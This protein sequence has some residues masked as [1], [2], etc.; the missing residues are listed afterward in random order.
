MKRKDIP[1]DKAARAHA[2]RPSGL[3]VSFIERN[4]LWSRMGLALSLVLAAVIAVLMLTPLPPDVPMPTGADKVYHFIAF[5]AL[6]FP[7]I[8]TDTER[9]SWAVPAAIVFGGAIEVI[10]PMVGRTAD[11]LDFG[12]NVA[13]VLAGAALAE[14]LH[15]RIR[16]SV[17]GPEPELRTSQPLLSEQERLEAMR[18]D[19][20]AELRAVLREELEA[21]ARRDDSARVEA[22]NGAGAAQ[23]E[24]P[25]SD[26]AVQPE[27]ITPVRVAPVRLRES[28]EMK[29]ARIAR[30]PKG[31]SFDKITGASDDDEALPKLH[32]PPPSG[33]TNGGG[34]TL[35]H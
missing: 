33:K 19:L 5:M 24:A 31:H 18:A 7:V 10:Q 28:A 20:M 23:D 1:Q 22:G 26:E 32:V 34:R 14:I 30:R 2:P 35:R 25:V 12:A 3:M 17:I 21:A 4:G 9:W 11:W 6:V 13:G 29:R 27:R 15:N 8:V 16:R